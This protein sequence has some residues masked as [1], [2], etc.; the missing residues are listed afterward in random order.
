MSIT[1]RDILHLDIASRFEQVSGEKGLDRPVYKVG[2]LDWESGNVITDSFINGEFVLT[3]LLAVKDDIHAFMPML[4]RLVKAGTGGIAI[5]KVYFDGLPDDMIAFAEAHDYPIFLYDET[6][7]EDIITEVVAAIRQS[8]ELDLLSLKVEQLL[9]GELSPHLV[10][11]IALELNPYFRK[12]YQVAY[13][14]PTVRRGRSHERLISAERI[15]GKHHRALPFREGVLLIRTFEVELIEAR[16]GL[17]ADDLDV[18][19]IRPEK[20]VIGLSGHHEQLQT[21]DQAVQE[22]LH[23]HRYAQMEEREKLSFSD[24]G[25]GRIL[26]PL[27]DNPWVI[28]YYETLITPLLQYDASHET[29]LLKTA[30][31]YVQCGMDI[32]ET[33]SKLYQHG[34][35][36][37]Y[38]LER[39]QQV[40]SSVIS[41]EHF[42][43]E[44]LLLVRLHQL[45]DQSTESFVKYPND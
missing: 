14:T 36:V 38:R 2:I 20:Y 23:A 34:N 8:Q 26:L 32:K 1:I 13:C 43:E 27:L 16:E 18:L 3:S 29:E 45:L 44:L 24:I 28:R 9:N 35:T 37:R 10:R 31:T 11:K 42:I 40:L 7:M 12:R 21:L 5:K 22:A 41:E 19:G 33:A 25:T 39:I 30:V 6:Y 17:M 4:E 15:L